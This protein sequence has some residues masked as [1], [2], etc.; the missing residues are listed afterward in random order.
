MEIKLEEQ[1][2]QPTLY[3]NRITTMKE[4]PEIL[5]QTFNEVLAYLNDLGSMPS[6]GPYATYFGFDKN[7]MN[8]DMGWLVSKELPEG[9]AI[10]FGKTLKGKAVVAIHKGPYGKLSD[11]YKK[12][13]DW[14]S[15]NGLVSRD[16]AYEYYLNS[17]DDVP[18]AELLTKVG[19]YI[20]ED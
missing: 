14:M 8:V 5:N 11:T 6:S 9:G 15:E 4:L 12:I 16:V 1:V 19:V 7:A 10:K 3:I 20:S 17:P 13:D 18:S 2:Q